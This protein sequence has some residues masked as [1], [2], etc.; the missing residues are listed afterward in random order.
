MLIAGFGIQIQFP[1]FDCVQVE[2][3]YNGPGYTRSVMI[4][5]LVFYFIYSGADCSIVVVFTEAFWR[6]RLGMRLKN[7]CRCT[8]LR[9][10]LLSF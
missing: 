5:T 6:L 4:N 8:P 10:W 1:K 2:T 3:Y 9:F 7:A